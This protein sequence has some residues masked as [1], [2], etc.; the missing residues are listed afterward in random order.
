MSAFTGCWGGAGRGSRSTIQRIASST[1]VAPIHSQRRW[2]VR[3]AVQVTRTS[4][5]SRSCDQSRS[6]TRWDAVPWPGWSEGGAV[7]PVLAG[8]ALPDQPRRDHQRAVGGER[9]V[10]GD[11]RQPRRHDA[12]PG[13]R[14]VAG[15]DQVDDVG[16]PALA[17]DDRDPVTGLELVEVRERRTRGGSVPDQDR[18]PGLARE[19][20]V[21]LEP[22]S[23]LRLVRRASLDE[24]LVEPDR[25]DGHHADGGPRG[26]R[27][28][29]RDRRRREVG[30]QV[31]V[32]HVLGTVRGESGPD[33]EVARRTRPANR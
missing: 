22:G 27:A 30:P 33:H 21:G 18:Q 26:D 19:H 3:S 10:G 32:E 28:G 7:V 24:D 23:E 9:R 6:A 13:R 29:D 5:S 14:R 20:G 2:A 15:A 8:S 31:A 25:G 11:Q 17:G 16:E 1:G 12:H 4:S